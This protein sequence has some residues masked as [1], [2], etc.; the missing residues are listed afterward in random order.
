[1]LMILLLALFAWTG[2]DEAPELN[3]N[4]DLV[5]DSHVNVR[6]NDNGTLDIDFS[7]DRKA[8]SYD[9]IDGPIKQY[10]VRHGPIENGQA[11]NQSEIMNAGADQD[12]VTL[13]NVKPYA[14]YFIQICA[15]SNS[16][17]FLF[18]DG[19]WDRAWVGFMDLSGYSTNEQPQGTADVDTTP[20]P[21]ARSIIPR[22]D[23]VQI[24][25]LYLKEDQSTNTLTVHFSWD[26]KESS[27]A[28]LGP[29]DHYLVRHGPVVKWDAEIDET[30][31][32]YSIVPNDTNSFELNE[33]TPG[34]LYGL[35]MCAVFT[36]DEGI[37]ESIDW[38]NQAWTG[39]MN[40]TTYSDY[41]SF[42]A[43]R[44]TTGASLPEE[45]SDAWFDEETV[46]PEPETKALN[47][48][49]DLVDVSHVNLVE[50]QQT[51]MLTVK[52]SWDKK[53]SSYNSLDTIDHYLVR[54]GPEPV[55]GGD[56]EETRARYL[57][58][59]QDATS[60][61][62]TDIQP[63]GYYGLQICASLTNDMGIDETVDWNRETWTGNLNFTTYDSY[64]AWITERVNSGDTPATDVSA[65]DE[66]MEEE[67][68]F[69]S[70]NEVAQNTVRDG[71]TVVLTPVQ[72]GTDYGIILVTLAIIAFI[73]IGAA[74]MWMVCSKRR[75][76]AKI[77][78]LSFGP[79]LTKEGMALP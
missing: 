26:K 79:I 78:P 39:S 36:E 70:K 60:F 9:S 69:G 31:A 75:R 2:A 12:T 63:G 35:Q 11:S 10:V 37:D 27:Y 41:S 49:C 28:Q 68:S 30:G 16:Y 47:P 29:I 33:I 40:F 5:A 66:D 1:M 14:E 53:E 25:H 56:I 3:P 67:P 76:Q 34:G 15:V 73:C 55:W 18:Q 48:R 17:R 54:H 13:K 77:A 46:T 71:Q 23:L 32:R 22:C 45:D 50:D 20:E 4:C 72:L 38:N 62:L 7:W 8:E 65:S 61:A 52:F 57:I 74:C 19:V 6:A 43:E 58:V 51:K 64:A 24:S 59:P 21:E 42:I 44:I